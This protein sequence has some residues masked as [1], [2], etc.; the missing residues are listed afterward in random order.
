MYKEYGELCHKKKWSAAVVIASLL[1]KGRDVRRRYSSKLLPAQ[2]KELG[3]WVVEY[4]LQVRA[5]FRWVSHDV[6]NNLAYD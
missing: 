2:R 1:A 4:G 5:Y 3:E 6:L